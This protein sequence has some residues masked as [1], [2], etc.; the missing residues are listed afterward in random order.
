M[1]MAEKTAKWT[2]AQLHRLPDD[3]NKYELVRG[4]LL[5]TPAPTEAHEEIATVLAEILQPYV[6]RQRL[7]RVY[8]PRAVIQLRGSETEPDV[9]V[10][11]AATKPFRSW[12][13]APLPNLV[14]EILS[15]STRRHDQVQKRD[16]Y[17]SL[18]IPEYWIVDGDQRTI[19]RVRPG[20]EDVVSTETLT[21]RP[22]NASEPLVIDLS[23][24][25]REAL[26]DA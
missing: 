7:G 12:A 4:E 11:S 13:K 2:L 15:E 24:L 1:H 8:R 14:V 5:V 6:T 26:G 9:M 16:L 10:R 17:T 20:S 22:A 23:A 18:G 19:R 3:G 21:W 25:F